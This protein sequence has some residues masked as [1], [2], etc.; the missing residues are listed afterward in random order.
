MYSF[1]CN[2][3]RTTTAFVWI[4]GHMICQDN[5]AYVVAPDVMD[6]PLPIQGNDN[7]RNTKTLPFRAHIMYNGTANKPL[8]DLTTIRAVRSSGCYNDTA[9]GCGFK[10]VTQSRTLNSWAFAANACAAAGKMFAGAEDGLGAEVWCGDGPPN[11]PKV[12]DSNCGAGCPG[13]APCPSCP[14]DRNETCGGGYMLQG[15][16]YDCTPLPAEMATSFRLRWGPWAG[17]KPRAGMETIPT[18]RFGTSLPPAEA[19]RD[20]MQK[21]LA[22]VRPTKCAG[23]PSLPQLSLSR[24]PQIGRVRV[25]CA[26]A[27]LGAL[28]AFEHA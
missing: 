5:H 26:F 2:F 3:S 6:N 10:Q 18:E 20:T 17:N 15:V 27:G 25:R 16:E 28:D 11:C 14:S 12:A 9:H 23:G 21:G 1:Y 22:Q 24:A 7:G 8:C 13:S 4:D 19:T